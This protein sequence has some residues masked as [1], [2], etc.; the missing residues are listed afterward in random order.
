[1][2]ER[3]ARRRDLYLTTHNTHNRQHIHAPGGI[4]IHDLSRRAAAY[5]RL[6]PRGHW[7]RQLLRLFIYISEECVNNPSQ[8]L[9]PRSYTQKQ[10]QRT[11]NSIPE[12]VFRRKAQVSNN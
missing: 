1:M 12:V 5:L 7:D 3:S 8:G 4:R 6:R 10:R 2:D 11:H 9:Y